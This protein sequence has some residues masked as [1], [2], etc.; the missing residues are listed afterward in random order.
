MVTVPGR[1]I[2]AEFQAIFFTGSGQLFQHIAFAVLPF[3]FAY[4]MGTEFTGPEAKAVVMFSGDN[5]GFHTGQFSG[6][7]PLAGIQ[8]CGIEDLGVFIGMSP[9]RVRKR[10]G[11]K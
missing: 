11:A 7:R 4:G 3:A 1:K 9:F 2:Y 8:L 5:D 6:T 10:I